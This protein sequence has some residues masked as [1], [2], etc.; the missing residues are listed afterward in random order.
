MKKMESHSIVSVR[1]ATQDLNDFHNI[2]LNLPLSRYLP[3][4]QSIASPVAGA[5]RRC[6][7]GNPLPLVKVFSCGWGY[8]MVPMSGC[9][10][11]NQS[12]SATLRSWR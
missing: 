9:D 1:H 5:Y 12:V 11:K 3:L 6:R 2:K 8:R 10:V 4:D 7:R